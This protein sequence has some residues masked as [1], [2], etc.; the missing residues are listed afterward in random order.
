MSSFSRQLKLSSSLIKRLQHR[1]TAAAAAGERS[2]TTTEGHRPTIVHKQGLDILHDPWFN[3]GTAFSMTERD[4]LDL[5]GLLPPNVMSSDQQIERFMADLKR[6]EV[7]ARDGP[8]DPNALAMWRILNRLHDRNETMYYK[9]LIAKIAEYAPIVYTPTVGLVCQN[10]SGLFRR[11]RGMYF[12]AAD[13]GEMMSMVYNWP[14]DQVDMIVVTDGS[15]ILGLGDLGIQGIGIAIGKLDLYV[16]AAGMNPQR[17]LPVM[18]DVGT[19]NE[20]LLKNPLYLGLQEHRLDGEEYV[21]VVDE[22]MEAVFTRWPNV[23][24]Q[25]EDFQ[26]KWAFKLLQRYRNIYR[27]FNDDVQG[28]AGVAIAGLLGAVRAQGKPLIDFPKMKIVVAGAGSAGIGVLNAARKT[29]ARMLGNNEYAF[30]SARSQ[31]WVVDAKG[32]ITEERENIDPDALPFA[33]KVKEI[34]RQGLMEGAS[35]EEVVRQVK[36]DVLLGL[37]AVGGLFS[38]EVLEALKCSTSTRPAI[39]AMSNPTKNA[40]C[41]PEEAFSVLGE[42]IIFASGS[43][44]KDVDLGN[45]HIGHCNQGNNMY[46]F[47]GIGLGTLLSGSRIISDGMLQAAAEC[48]AE[49]MTEEEV[50]KGII[51][52]PISRIRDI[53]KEVAAAVI[54]EAIEEDLAEGYREMDARELQKLNQFLR[55]GTAQN[56][57]SSPLNESSNQLLDLR[58]FLQLKYLLL[59]FWKMAATME[60]LIGLVN[61]IQRACTALGDYGGGDTAFSSLWDSLPSVAVVG[62]QS[63]GKSSVLES[64]V[65]RDFLPRGSGIVTRRPLV[66]QLYRIDE[67]QDY[68]EFSHLPRRKFSD[69][70]MVRKEIED[71]TD[72]LTGKSKQISPVPIHLSIYSPNE[73]QSENIVQDIENMVRSYIEK[74]NSIILAISPANQ[75]I[76][77]S[78]AIKIAREVDPT[79]DRTFGVLTKLDLMDKGTNA[80]DV[81]EGRSYRLQQPWVGIVNRSQADINKNVDMVI[82]RRKER[83]YFATSPDYGHLASKMG[84]EYL[85]KLLS[86]HLESVIR[87]RIPSITSLINK[88]ID[89][90]ESEMDHLGR[91][92]GVDAGAQLYTILELCR[93]FDRIFKEHLDGGR[94]GGDRIYGVFDNQLPAA[95]RKLP[96]DRHLSLQNVKKVVSEADGY[97]PHLIAP[98]Q[99]YRRLIEGSLN[100]FRGPAEAS[101][102]AVHFVLKELVRKSIGETQELRRFPSLQAE[103]AAAAG[104]ALE[105]FREESK[106][107]VV[108]LVDMESSYLTVDFF[109]KLPQEIEN[110]GNRPGGPPAAAAAPAIDRYSEGHFRRIASNVSSYVGM[111]SETIRI[112]IPKA[113][114]YCQVKEAK[115]NLL[116]YFYTQI[117]KKEGA[118]LGLLLDEDPALMER[119]QQCAKR[120]ELYKSARD[121]IDSVSWIR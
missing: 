91:P 58:V 121:E 104:E 34:G 115:Q 98:E 19:N 109:R 32:L 75:D 24:V 2:F 70:A 28:T 120:L 1:A 77:T 107:T 44:F 47:P 10:Y 87:A 84:S 80:L 4:R 5:R 26:S 36:P 42:N 81:L 95:L 100:Y 73:G 92:I 46:L 59:G 15:R 93:A 3:K 62:G 112:T 82:A 22:F 65:G 97:Q 110:M 35:L 53:T 116:N 20:K 21:E 45:G 117:G 54:K 63:S 29:M 89:E 56:M 60:S 72:R 114:V 30:E 105:R 57:L 74:P 27:M 96:F 118:Q 119:R 85:A 25:F 40:E 66:L 102:D 61:R 86:K 18:I 23:I 17:V 78:D 12:S 99:G 68:A 79:G 67:G 111:V 83:E 8:S 49:Y 33:R 7:N 48:L 106:K 101:V 6:L 39:F 41:T 11:P 52:P 88:S 55:H 37:S 94:P 31:F 76:A 38:K 13:R 71:E 50:L 64:I 51:F 113:V 43:P 69:F 103:I 14:A 9:V 108:R 90:L 16:A